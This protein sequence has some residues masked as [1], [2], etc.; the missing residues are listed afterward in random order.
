MDEVQLVR[1][2]AEA[3]TAAWCSQDAAS[4]A[5]YYEENGTWLKP[6]RAGELIS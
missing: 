4:V 3:Y 6:M 2:L 1:S 5:A